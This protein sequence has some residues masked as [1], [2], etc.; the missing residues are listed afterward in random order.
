METLRQIIHNKIVNGGPI[1][2]HDFMEYALYYPGLGYYN[3]PLPKIGRPGDY[4]T[5][6]SLSPTFG[7]LIARQL[8]EMW[9]ILGRGAFTII[10]YG[11]G[12]GCLC[13]SILS[14]LAEN[15]PDMFAV[16]H[17][18]II[19][20]SESMKAAQ[21]EL[22]PLDKVNWI[23]DIQYAGKISGCI[24]SNEVVDNFAV[25]RVVMEQTL[26][27]IYVTIQG[28]CFS[29][30][31]IP[32][33]Q[34]IVRYFSEQNVALPAHYRT[35]VN[36]QALT[37][38]GH[39][40]DSLE[41][42]FVLTIDYGYT[43]QDYY[44]ERRN[45]GTLV[46]YSQHTRSAKPYEYVGTQDIT[47]HVNFS[48]L[49]HWGRKAGLEYAG[50]IDQC[51]FLRSLG[52]VEMLRAKEAEQ[53]NGVQEVKRIYDLIQMKNKFKVL[54]QKK[55]IGTTETTGMMFCERRMSDIM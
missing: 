53:G 7:H 36:L 20:K 39:V 45:E 52:I 17:Y 40:S 54:L 14:Y 49:C 10:E 28:D 23:D 21:A 13:K 38:I 24:L 43:A 47:T 51:Y 19:E 16:L 8:E 6:P 25:H 48:A 33:P 5:C 37:W 22:L 1:S 50:F 26:K 29:E 42:G 31:L 55:G 2:F 32:A 27:E 44:H 34:T 4:C 35:E 11:A 18:V 46:C 15:T 30:I 12:T 3:T 41:K 9:N